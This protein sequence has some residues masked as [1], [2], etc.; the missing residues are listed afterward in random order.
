MSLGPMSWHIFPKKTKPPKQRREIFG[1]P[2]QVLR[3][4]V[5]EPGRGRAPR[6]A[7]PRVPVLR[8]Q[9]VLRLQV[10]PQASRQRRTQVLLN[11][12]N[13]DGDICVKQSK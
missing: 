7:V 3:G 6:G 4:E 8:V 1:R 2:L 5:L 9:G 10:G 12:A 13:G 11:D